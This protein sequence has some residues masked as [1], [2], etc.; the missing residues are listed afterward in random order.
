MISKEVV[1][2]AI[3]NRQVVEFHYKGHLRK[4]EP[5]LVGTR[6]TGNIELSAFQTG[7]YSE[8]RSIPFWRG[9]LLSGITNWNPT[10]ET[11][12]GT[13]DGYNQNDKR[14]THIYCRL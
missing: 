12:N 3:N 6:T 11:F 1:C 14:M 7:G 5:H 8:S 9:Y 2:E 4:V 10:E 13:R